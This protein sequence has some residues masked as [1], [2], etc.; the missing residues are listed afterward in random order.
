[1]NS[2]NKLLNKLRWLQN[3]AAD[4]LGGQGV[5]AAA[6]ATTTTEWRAASIAN[7]PRMPVA[8]F[9][10]ACNSLINGVELQAGS[11]GRQMEP[12]G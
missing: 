11:A 1:M 4:A 12:L 5:G 7:L 2:T 10:A 8:S 9:P 6:A 3:A